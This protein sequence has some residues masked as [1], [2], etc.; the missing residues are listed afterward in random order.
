MFVVTPGQQ[1][2]GVG[3]TTVTAN[4]AAVAGEFGQEHGF[5]VLAV[6]LDPQAHLTLSLAQRPAPGR[7]LGELL[8]S[9]IVN[10]PTIDDVTIRDVMPGVD[11]LPGDE[12]AL[13]RAEN[14]I[15]NDQISG[16]T[17]LRVLLDSVADRY[18]L[19]FIDTPPKVEGLAVVAMVASDGVIIVAEP[20][21]LSF[22]STRVYAAKVQQVAN[23]PLN[24]RLHVLGTLLNKVVPGEEATLITEAMRDMGMHVFDT[25]I[26]LSKL[27]SKAAGNGR[28]A[29]LASRNYNIGAIYRAA[30]DEIIDRLQA[31]VSARAAS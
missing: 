28:P 2:G 12:R 1:K 24:P 31:A 11:L 21:A 14:D 8:N 30:A 4:L 3:K 17:R 29:A 22:A 25:Q 15:E 19:A 6:D 10:P 16:L 23:S 18:Q 9:Q 26:P 20:S 5:K 27:A 7:S 13:E